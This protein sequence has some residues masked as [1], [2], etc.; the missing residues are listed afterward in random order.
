MSPNYHLYR[1]FVLS[2]LLYLYPTF[3][4]Y[5]LP[6]AIKSIIDQVDTMEHGSNGTDSVHGVDATISSSHGGDAINEDNSTED[7][8]YRDHSASRREGN[9][10]LL[11]VKNDI[12]Q[13]ICD[14]KLTKYAATWYYRIVIYAKLA[15]SMPLS[16]EGHGY[17]KEVLKSLASLE[18]IAKS[19]SKWAILASGQ[20]INLW[21]F[22]LEKGYFCYQE[23]I[24]DHA[25]QYLKLCQFVLPSEPEPLIHLG[26]VYHAMKDYKHALEYYMAYMDLG[27]TSVNLYMAIAHIQHVN[28]HCTDQAVTTLKQALR[29]FPYDDSILNELCTLYRAM[30]QFEDYGKMILADMVSSR[31]VLSDHMHALYAYA[32]YL[33]YGKRMDQA[34]YHYQLILKHEPKNYYALYQLG[35]I[36]QDKCVEDFRVLSEVAKERSLY[37]LWTICNLFRNYSY[38][39]PFFGKDMIIRYGHG[40]YRYRIM[41]GFNLA[42]PHLWQ[43]SAC[44]PCRVG[45]ELSSM[46]DMDQL[47]RLMICGSR[48]TS[49]MYDFYRRQMQFKKT[50]GQAASYFLKAYN[51]NRKDPSLLLT[52]YYDYLYLKKY[53]LTKL[54]YRRLGERYDLDWLR[55]H[56]PFVYRW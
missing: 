44:L 29:K 48:M 54:F 56:N 16:E 38:L 25:I 4:L 20:L 42:F 15:R 12:D 45:V 21:N 28:L 10:P 34:I 33:A 24:F 8:E 37:S 32:N 46:I 51:Q 36:Y 17:L 55:E 18:K 2:L 26:M 49:V 14:E 27:K 11:R 13:A 31:E 7:V 9:V 6:K 19:S 23:G 1:R 39:F 47:Q 5:A 43:A 3:P 41:H 52:L 53:R 35:L 40:L 22:F 30:D 50:V